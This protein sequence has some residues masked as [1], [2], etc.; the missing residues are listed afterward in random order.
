M[1]IASCAPAVQPT[2]APAVTQAPVAT[3][4]PAVTQAPAPV[5]PSPKGPEG[6]SWS[7]TPGKPYD[8]QQ[9][10]VAMIDEPREHAFK[11][12]LSTF[13]ELTGIDVTIDF[14]GFDDLYNKNIAASA[15]KT[16]EYDVYQLHVPDMALFDERGY[17]VNLTD[18][19]KRDAEQMELNDIPVALQESHMKF[20]DS[21]WGVPTHVGANQFYYRKDIFEKEG[22]QLPKTWD[23]VL[24]IAKD[25]ESKYAPEMHGFAF[26]GS[27]DIQGASTYMDILGAYGGD[28]FDPKTMK[29]T[30]NSPEALKAMQMLVD[31][32]AVSVPG[33]PSFGFDQAHVAFAKG[34]A[35]MIPFWDSGDNFFSDPKQSDIVGKWA[36]MVM[37][38]G[39]PTNGGWSVQISADSTHKEAAWEFLKWIISP[40][41]ERETVPLTPACRSSILKDPKYAQYPA[42]LAFDQLL[43]GNPFAFPKILP[44]WQILQLTGQTVNA[45]TAGQTKPADGLKSLQTQFEVIFLRYGIWNGQ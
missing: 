9:I 44:N 30:I 15:A 3:E 24:T 22:Y 16:G 5:G 10:H 29:P 26:M 36:E 33:S 12:R 14:F 23:D 4:A 38:G 31:L 41:M 39:R 2:S 6:Y 34:Q 43:Q 21:Y 40:E 28:F 17:M 32:T 11:D 20:K 42:Y 8:G 1:I 27:A 19:V 37:P 25:V 45:V 18:W 35:A 7:I 13:K